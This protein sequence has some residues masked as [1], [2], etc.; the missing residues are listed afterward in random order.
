MNISPDLA[1]FRALADGR[2]VISVHARIVADDVTPIALYRAL[3]GERTNTFLFESAEA[4]VW[5]RYSFIGV[6]T[7]ATLTETDG[8]ARWVGR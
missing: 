4:G 5:S 2:R 3:C 1:Q 6:R 7:A 8:R